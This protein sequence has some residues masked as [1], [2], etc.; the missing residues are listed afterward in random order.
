M[1]ITTNLESVL[2]Y[3]SMN[4]LERSEVDLDFF[5][6]D[7]EKGLENPV[8]VRVILSVRSLEKD[9]ELTFP[10]GSSHVV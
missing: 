10:Y 4:P 8:V 6:V 5:G 3:Y 1:G 7:P 2:E 9:E